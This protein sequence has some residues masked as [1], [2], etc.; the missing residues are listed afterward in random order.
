[1]EQHH[2]KEFEEMAK[3]RQQEKSKAKKKEVDVC[4]VSTAEAPSPA[5]GCIR[6]LLDSD[7]EVHI[8]PAHLHDQDLQRDLRQAS[9]SLRDASGRELDVM[10]V[11]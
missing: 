8:L 10:G 6:A 9:V 2:G 4:A 7:A 1:V 11:C 3:K 5:P